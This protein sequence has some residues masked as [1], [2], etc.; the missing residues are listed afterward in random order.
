LRFEN[1]AH[2]MFSNFRLLDSIN[3]PQDLIDKAIEFGMAGIALT[4]HETIAGIPEFFEYA[5]SIRKDHPNFK[6]AAGNEIY[7]TGSRESNQRYYHF[8]LIAKNRNGWEALKEL[9]SESWMQS[10]YDRG[11]ERV[12][13][14]YTE[15]ENIL[16]KYPSSLIG[17]TACL[18]GELSTT[19]LELIEAE[20][21]GDTE[22]AATAHKHIVSFLLWCK[23][24]FK[25]DFFIECAPG[26]SKD[27]IAVNQRL[28]S[29]AKAFD[30][31]MV[32][33]SDAHYLRPEN[34][35]AH[36][37]YLNSKNGEREVKEFYEYAYLQTDEEIIEH[38][39][40]SN[41]DEAYVKRMFENSVELSNKI[42]IYSIW[43][44]QTIPSVEVKDYP[45]IKT[46]LSHPHLKQMFESDDKYDRYW[47]NQCF[48]KLEE[49][50][51]NSPQYLE[52][53][54]E[55]AETKK[56]VGDKL[57]TNLFKYPIV[58]Q[59]Y[60]DMF[61]ELGSSIGAGRGSS[62]A[63]LNHYLLGITQLDPIK[64][65][66]PWFRYLNKE[67]VELPSLLLILGSIKK[68]NCAN[69]CRVYG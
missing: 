48:E 35:Y 56:F 65:N 3:K 59:H 23:K 12:P 4:D 32:V 51:L 9:S 18:A 43:H 5:E 39:K 24:I 34:A 58:L 37:A 40:K 16:K 63:G 22:G 26:C 64:W 38:L 17:T 44:N 25:D 42:E 31:K 53:L 61:W 67:R 52:R 55:E 68:V 19:T 62:C 36:E 15:L 20:R 45:K 8:I 6:V 50:N 1:H 54:E 46:N 13:T 60:I 30:L 21:L 7:L 14:L 2:S 41:Y 28:L 49:K 11:M 57:G 33:G 69:R 29:I 27:Q 47:V 10:Y 66:F